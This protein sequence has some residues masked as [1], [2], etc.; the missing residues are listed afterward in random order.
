MI[1]EGKIKPEDKVKIDEKD[2]K[3]IITPINKR[4]KSKQE[5]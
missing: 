4:T 1:I 5:K 3:I 2:E